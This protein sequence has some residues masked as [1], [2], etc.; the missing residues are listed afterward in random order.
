MLQPDLDGGDAQDVRRVQPVEAGEEGHDEQV[1]TARPAVREELIVEGPAIRRGVGAPEALEEAE[2][3][4][5][6]HRPP[7]LLVLPHERVGVEAEGHVLQ[8]VV[9]QELGVGGVRARP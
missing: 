9:L 3:I 5:L 1:G 7:G 8:A 6:L 4:A 2:G